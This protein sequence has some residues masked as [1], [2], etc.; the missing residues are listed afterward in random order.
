MTAYPELRAV[1]TQLTGVLSDLD[2]L[3]AQNSELADQLKTARIGAALVPGLQARIAE[4][5]AQVAELESG[6]DPEPEPE[7]EPPAQKRT[8]FGA[9][10]LDKGAAGVVAKYGK[11]ATVRQF[12]TPLTVPASIP[13]G[14]I[15]HVSAKPASTITDAEIDAWLKALKGHVVTIRHEP[16]NDGMSSAQIAEWKTLNNRVYDRNVA[17]GRP[18]LVAPTFT[19]GLFASYGNDTTRDLWM[20]GL[21]GDLL[22]FDFDG[23]HDNQTSKPAD[24][25]YR[26][27]SKAITNA[28]EIANAK[29]YIAKYAA[30]GWQG[31]TVPE[32]GISRATWDT[33][34]EG[35]A[36]WIRGN[37]GRFIEA[38]TYLCHWYDFRDTKTGIS[39]IVDAGSPE[40]EALSELVAAN[41]TR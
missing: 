12:F 22:G 35:R 27:G 26:V 24:L 28:D 6:P 38:D 1:A 39:D 19:G 29:R 4:L 30:N 41:P 18:C 10:I 31:I 37:G 11:G 40:H 17:L 20:D 16:D 21:N 13:A 25:V 3:I 23:V 36:K 34:G 5:M 14:T 2:T 9:C 32:F 15:M 8:I 33:T 7:P